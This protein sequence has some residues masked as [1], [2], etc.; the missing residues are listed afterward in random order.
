MPGTG[1]APGGSRRSLHSAQGQCPFPT[2]AS[3]HGF[4]EA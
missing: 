1:T 2:L 4:P 3:A